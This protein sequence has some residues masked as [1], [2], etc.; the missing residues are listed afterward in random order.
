MC[1]CII[2]PRISDIRTCLNVAPMDPFAIWRKGLRR[3]RS[4]LTALARVGNQG[5]PLLAARLHLLANLSSFRF[6]RTFQESHDIHIYI[7]G[8]DLHICV[9]FAFF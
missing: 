1:N 3:V 6:M 9:V 8:L 7:L 5:N 4:T 2:I